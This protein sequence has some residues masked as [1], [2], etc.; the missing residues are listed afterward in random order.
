[1][2]A[3]VRRYTGPEAGQ[4]F[5]ELERR[6]GDVERIIRE[7]PGFVAYTLMRTSDGGCSVTVCQDRAGCEESSRRAAEWIRQNVAAAAGRPPEVMEGTVLLNLGGTGMPAG[8]QPGAAAEAG[9]RPN[10]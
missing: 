9:S 2:H 6:T 5:G 4:L 8:Q 1:M 7:V 10:A 3:V